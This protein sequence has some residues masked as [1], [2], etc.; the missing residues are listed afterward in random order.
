MV[1]EFTTYHCTCSCI[2]FILESPY[3]PVFQC[4]LFKEEIVVHGKVVKL[5]VDYVQGVALYMLVKVH[6]ISMVIFD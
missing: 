5:Y 2:Y 3:E 4:K 6:K 1:T